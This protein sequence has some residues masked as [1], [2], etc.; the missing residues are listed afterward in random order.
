MFDQALASY[1][2]ALREGLRFHEEAGRCW[3][4]LLAQAASRQEWEKQ[5]SALAS[6]AIP[7]TQKSLEG[8]LG[9]LE[10][11]SRASVEMLKKGLEA[12]QATS[13]AEGQG[14]LVDFVESSLRSLRTQAQA[15]VELNGKAV[16]SW[17]GL[18]KQAAGEVAERKPEKA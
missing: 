14:R 4:K 15:V 13:V 16:D 11:N 10:Q 17:I 9:L 3:A 6:D 1:E 8:Y 7:A 18:V 2:Q 12:A 5:L